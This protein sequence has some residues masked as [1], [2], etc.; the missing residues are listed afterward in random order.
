MVMADIKATRARQ[1]RMKAKMVATV[2]ADKEVMKAI[3]EHCEWAPHI[4]ATHM[5]TAPKDQSSSVLP[6]D[7]KGAMYGETVGATED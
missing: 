1:E 2:K 3:V 7:P 4:N 5:L 6:R